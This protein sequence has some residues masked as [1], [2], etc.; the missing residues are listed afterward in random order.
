MPAGAPQEF[1]DARAE[2]LEIRPR[3]RERAA[4][5]QPHHID[6]RHRAARAAEDHERAA[7]PE[8][9]EARVERR[10][11]DAVV[12][13]MHA[14]A[15][16]QPAHFGGQIVERAMKHHVVRAVAARERRLPGGR[17]SADHPHAAPLEPLREQQPDAARRRVNEHDVAF[18]GAI[19]IVDEIVR[20]HALHERGGGRAQVDPVRHGDRLVLGHHHARRVAAHHGRPRDAIARL[21]TRDVR[22]D[23]E[24]APGAL[25]AR[26]AGQRHRIAALAA[27]QIDEIHARR[28]ELDEQL[29]AARLARG[30][31]HVLENVGAARLADF[32]GLH[33][34]APNVRQ[35][36]S[37]PARRRARHDRDRA[38]R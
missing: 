38:S 2:M 17:H 23:R 7:R 1:V 26:R 27:I 37:P 18:A 30:A 34:F 31:R 8:A 24:H 19:R 28:G 16:R 9:R 14:A 12:H 15:V 36:I 35:G 11:A 13:R 25:L 20:G 3:E 10:R 4:P 5:Q 29:A 32:D 21:E 33:Q 22:P 6:G